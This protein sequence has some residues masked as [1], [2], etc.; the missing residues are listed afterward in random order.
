[1]LTLA[2]NIVHLVSAHRSCNSGAFSIIVRHSI[3]D[4]THIHA[5]IQLSCVQAFRS[6]TKAVTKHHQAYT[7]NVRIFFRF[8]ISRYARENNYAYTVHYDHDRA[9]PELGPIIRN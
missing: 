2:R 9:W 1:M 4:G 6:I 3:T 7:N 8:V 5:P